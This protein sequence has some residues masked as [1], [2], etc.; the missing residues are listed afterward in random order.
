VDTE[1]DGEN[2]EEEDDKEEDHEEED[3]KEEDEDEEK[4]RDED[5]GKEPRRI[6][7]EQMIT[8]LADDVDTMLH[9]QAL[10]LPEESHKMREHTTW[11]QR[12]APAT[13]LQTPECHP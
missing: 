10:G 6:G 3:G 2:E 7:P 1:T 8:T 12:Q 13:W 5:E 9:Y 11:K 4:D